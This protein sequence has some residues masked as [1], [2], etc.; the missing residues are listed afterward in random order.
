MWGEAVEQKLNQNFFYS[1]RSSCFKIFALTVNLSRVLVLF[2]FSSRF[3]SSRC[4]RCELIVLSI[5]LFRDFRF[6]NFFSSN[7]VSI[8]HQTN[9]P[10][11]LWIIA[12]V[13]VNYY[14]NLSACD[15]T[16]DVEP[17]FKLTP[18][19]LF[20]CCNITAV[21]LFNAYLLLNHHCKFPVNWDRY[22]LKW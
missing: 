22:R 12:S 20:I 19:Q 11:F 6:I 15:I 7:Q 13:F 21:I 3:W 14:L 2:G 10:I 5:L 16:Y 18:H 9:I 4:F 8:S 17:H 1:I